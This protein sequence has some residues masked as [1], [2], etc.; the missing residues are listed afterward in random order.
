MVCKSICESSTGF[1]P[2]ERIESDTITH[3]CPSVAPG[4]APPILNRKLSTPTSSLIRGLA[5]L[6]FVLSTSR[7]RDAPDR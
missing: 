3:G 2:R 4:V 5:V 7:M 1:E 6:Q